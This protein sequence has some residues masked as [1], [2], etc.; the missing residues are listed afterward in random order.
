M[1]KAT[2]DAKTF[3]EDVENLK[4]LCDFIRSRQ[5]PNPREALLME[6]RVHY[7]KGEKLVNFLVEPKKGTKWPSNL[8]KFASRNEALAVAKEMAKNQFLLRA[9]KA[10]KGELSV[11]AE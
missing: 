6:K 1:S 7:V 2:T 8:P 9:E 11:R 10:A 5:G 4:K 3:Y